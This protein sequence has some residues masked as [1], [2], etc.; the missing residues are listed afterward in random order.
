MKQINSKFLILFAIILLS[1]GF[2]IWKNDLVEKKLHNNS[3]S[4]TYYNETHSHQQRSFQL[5]YPSTFIVNDID[6]GRLWLKKNKNST[7]PGDLGIEEVFP[8]TEFHIGN[9]KTQDE[10]FKAFYVDLMGQYGKHLDISSIQ[11]N[12]I[13]FNKDK[14]FYKVEENPVVGIDTHLPGNRYI[15]IVQGKGV[16]IIDFKRLPESI[17]L[18][19]TRSIEIRP[20]LRK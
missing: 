3:Q 18:D 6:S 19:I 5:Q 13:D 2:W 17:I 10:Q 7:D 15:G 9:P 11:F 14:F 4:W 8:F 16:E 20:D 1:G 12:R